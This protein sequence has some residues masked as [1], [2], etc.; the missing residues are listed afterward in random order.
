MTSGNT[1]TPTAPGPSSEKQT[2]GAGWKLRPDAVTLVHL[3][4]LRSCPTGVSAFMALGMPGGPWDLCVAWTAD[5]D[6]SLP[7]P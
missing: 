6:S 7:D 2:G 1:L 4:L 5:P 3:P